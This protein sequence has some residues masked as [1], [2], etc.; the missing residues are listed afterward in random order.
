MEKFNIKKCNDPE[1]RQILNFLSQ[2]D[3]EIIYNPGKN[4]LEAD[5]L[6]RN[7]VLV[8]DSKEDEK[9]IIK[10]LNFLKLEEIINNQ[11]Q[12]KLD[13]N[14]ESANDI[15]YKTLNNKKKIWLTEEFGI[16]LIKNV[17][18]KQE[19]IGTKQLT[20]TITHKYYFKIC[21]NT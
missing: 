11:K 21:I 6:S 5:C 1:L 13:N 19:H 10:I 18:N 12:L 2:F 7:P 9:S 8:E 3:F 15:I 14:Y 20:L 4:N 17:H 16:A